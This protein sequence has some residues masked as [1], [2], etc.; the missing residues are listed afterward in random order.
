MV[1]NYNLQ[2]K[3]SLTDLENIKKKA[4]N[5]NRTISNYVKTLIIEDLKNGV[6]EDGSK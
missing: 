3:I 5:Q 6:E 4:M 2:T 1:E